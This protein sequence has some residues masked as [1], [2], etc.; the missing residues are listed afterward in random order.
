MHVK[1]DGKMIRLDYAGRSAMDVEITGWT[2]IAVKTTTKDADGMSD[3]M[4]RVCEPSPDGS[5]GALTHGP[6][7]LSGFVA[8]V[9]AWRE[10]NSRWARECFADFDGP[11]AIEVRR[12]RR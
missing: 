11:Q 6:V 12:G 8:E 10:T 7:S 9:Q 3:C 5:V 2:W 4:F 1:T